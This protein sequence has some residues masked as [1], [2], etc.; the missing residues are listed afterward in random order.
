VERGIAKG[1]LAL[2]LPAAG[3]YLAY[4]VPGGRVRLMDLPPRDLG[5]LRRAIRLALD[6]K[7]KEMPEP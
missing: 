1:P 7:L 5:T 3:G 2:S 6:A 4:A